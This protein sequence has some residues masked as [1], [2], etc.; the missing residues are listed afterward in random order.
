MIFTASTNVM[1]D[2]RII[3]AYKKINKSCIY[4]F[5]NLDITANINI[6]EIKSCFA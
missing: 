4:D 2:N 6:L 1:E 5:Y 3:I